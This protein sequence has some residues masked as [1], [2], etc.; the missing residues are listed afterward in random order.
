MP[1]RLSARLLALTACAVFAAACGQPTPEPALTESQ[2]LTL[3]G[4]DTGTLDVTATASEP[5]QYCEVDP[6]DNSATDSDL[7]VPAE[8][9]ADL[10]VTL[11]ESADPALAGSPLSYTVQVANTGP[12]AAN[13]VW[14]SFLVPE[15]STFSGATGTGWS[16]EESEGWVT[17]TRSSLPSGGA[18]DITITVIPTTEGTVLGALV[19]VVSLEEDP[20]NA[21]NHDLETT[22]ISHENASPVNT[23]PAAPST[24]EDTPLV[25][26]TANGNAFSIADPDAVNGLIQVTLT[27]THGTLTLDSTAGLKLTTGDGTS[28]TTITFTSILDLINLALQGLTFVPDANYNG[29]ATLTITTNDQGSTG[30]GGPKSDTDTVEISVTPVNGS[31]TEDFERRVVGSGC[32]A[33]GGNC[34]TGALWV[35]LA[36]VGFAL[37]GRRDVRKSG[38]RVSKA[39]VALG[40]LAVLGG[41]TPAQAQAS[42]SAIDVQLFKPAPGKEDVLGL[43]GAGV[44]GNMNWHAG[45][46]LNYAHDPLV[47][48][49]PRSDTL[50]QHLVK[51]QLGFDFMGAIGLGERVEVGAVLPLNL[52]HGELDRQPNLEQQWT[53][54][55]GDLRLVPKALLLSGERLRLAL[56]V[57]VVLPTGG[58]TALRGQDGVGVQPRVA[59]DYAFEGGTRLLANVGVNLRSRQELLNLSVGNELAYSLGAAIPFRL[60]EQQFTGLASL[61]GAF[62]LGA[63]GGADEEEI[64]LEV[65]AGL[66]YHFSKS[67]LATLGLGRGLTLG[68]GMPVF[69]VFTGVSWTAEEEAARTPPQDTDGDGIPA[70]EDKCPTEAEDRDN[71]QDEDG[72]PDPDNDGDG[73]LDVADQCP[74]GPEDKDGF[75][76]EDGCPDSDNDGDGILDVADKCP[77]KPEDKDGFQDED[78]CPDPDNDRDGFADAEDK[79][80]LEAEVINGVTDEDGCPDEGKPVVQVQD[81]KIL[82]LEK[83]HF[84][85]NKD[86]VLARSFPLLQQV[87]AVL[88]ANPQLK[89]VRI[90]GHTDDR[91]NDAFNM[92][93]SQRRANNVRKHLVEQAKIAS[94]RLESV[95]YGETQPVDT[96]KTAAGRE[97]NRRVAFS[98][99]EVEEESP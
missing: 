22:A 27:V 43:H 14:V 75:E 24:P 3:T 38:P 88:R 35:F 1:P 46:Y 60:Q 19:S 77:L 87:A 32:S 18:S 69:R 62:G 85:T 4:V 36:L 55:I 13:Y 37:F 94:E 70:P 45:L 73:I 9:V 28:D 54:G 80:P 30:A 34:L 57:P 67:V 83:V 12:A 53:G 81:K 63:T 5:P 47:V 78:G 40:G 25:F 71:F 15:G 7:L 17:C 49:N 31:P 74:M 58:A 72:C 64:P 21:N 29:V 23:V 90:E 97:N 86:V 95:G 20:S 98:I 93:L 82:I 59:A 41:S 56:A 89:K 61:G 76:D 91:A 44:P 16:C 39:L 33:A 26:S 8:D 52:Q 84:A 11:S 99:L 42:G 92:D 96:N 48:I 79:C 6:T 50:L 66:Q 51:N 2:A 68:Y 10:S 65:Q